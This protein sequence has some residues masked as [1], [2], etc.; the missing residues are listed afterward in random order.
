MTEK[1]I[2]K[3]SLPSPALEKGVGGWLFKNLFSSPGNALLTVI[4]LALMVWAVPP[5]LRWALL[6]ANWI[7]E[8]RSACDS[9]APDA[10]GG[11]CWVFIKVRLSLFMYGFYP[12]P[13]RWRVNLIFVVLA[14][15]MWPLLAPELFKDTRKQI[16]LGLIAVVAVLILFGYLAAVF[17]VLF[18]FL[19]IGLAQISFKKNILPGHT[20]RSV[21][22]FMGAG[23]A[24]LCGLIIYLEVYL[25]IDKPAAPSIGLLASLV[26]LPLLFAKRLTVTAWRWI[27]LFTV[28]PLFAYFLIV[29][30]VLGLPHVETHYWGGLFLTLVV[31][32]SGMATALPIGILLA[33]GRRSEMPV[34]KTICVSF[35]EFVRGVPLV[36]VLFMASVM[37]PLFLP[38]NVSIDKLLRALVGISFFYAA[39][40]AEVVRGGLQAIPKGQYEAAQALGWSYWKMMGLIILPQTLRLVIPGL[41]NNFL[42][43]LKDTTLVAV[44][45]L[46]DLLGIAKAAM[47]DVEWLGFTK[48]AYVFAGAV[49]W[50]FCFGLSRYSVYLEK[51][52][53]TSY[54]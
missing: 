40:M 39:Y 22:I 37:F 2:P 48:E 29:G 8:T 52:Y 36:S 43:L 53:H 18:F 9:L 28:Y 45:G 7:G 50:I 41:A 21:G 42:S 25:F 44:I 46:L 20:P 31:A 51:K 27:F 14:L 33:L 1:W 16:V 5:F 30:G 35:I 24:A 11:A 17:M 6:D 26:C 3:P 32:C 23:I 15:A 4:G 13:E 54:R 49:F 19:P 38:E 47:A 12:D 34:I 10:S